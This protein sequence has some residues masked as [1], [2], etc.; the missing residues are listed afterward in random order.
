MN[1]RA[2]K[3]KIRHHFCPHCGTTVYWDF[4]LRPE[5]YGIAA[6][7]FEQPPDPPSYSAWEIARCDWAPLPG[8][9]RTFLRIRP[10]QPRRRSLDFRNAN[11]RL[12]GSA[13]FGRLSA[14]DLLQSLGSRRHAVPIAAQ[15]VQA[16]APSRPWL[17]LRSLGFGR[18]IA[19]IPI[20]G[21]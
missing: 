16:R 3:G 7:L 12:L 2:K 8:E 4:D 10:R 15:F 5:R 19:S 13:D 1:V 17:G 20:A 6:G 14:I 11:L 21:R 9:C 18:N